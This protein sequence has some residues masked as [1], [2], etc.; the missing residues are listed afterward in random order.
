MNPLALK[1]SYQTIEVHSRSFTLAARFLAPDVRDRAVV[2]YGWCRHADDA[3]DEAKTREEGATALAALHRELDMVYGDG[4]IDDTVLTAFREV[5][6]EGGIAREYPQELLAGL[7]MDV[8]GYRYTYMEPLLQY[9]YRVAGTVGLMM[10]HVMGVHDEAA[11]RNA[12]HLGIA[13]QLTNICR[14]VEFDWSIGRLYVPDEILDAHGIG[15][16]HDT[17]GGAFPEEAREPMKGAI[18]DLLAAADGFYRSGYSGLGALSW[19]SSLS[20]RVAGRVYEAIGERLHSMDCDPLAG[21]AIVT[22]PRKIAL[23]ASCIAR[24]AS[25]TPWRL[26]AVLRGV[27][28]RAPKTILRFPNDI[29]PLGAR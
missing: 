18:R 19:R 23:T 7:D 22:R 25:E 5:C 3:I 6:R 17:L 12:V 28:P 16:L 24:A 29:L 10:C 4:P 13:M 8:H 14:D 26:P 1:L 20:I 2:L 15:W 27:A 11:T 9:C 21:R